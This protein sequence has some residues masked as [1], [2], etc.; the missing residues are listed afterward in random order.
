MT[1]LLT[2]NIQ[3][4]FEIQFQIFENSPITKKQNDIRIKLTNLENRE[5]GI[6]TIIK[7]FVSLFPEKYKFLDRYEPSLSSIDEKRQLRMDFTSL[8][9]KIYMNHIIYYLIKNKQ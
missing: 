6:K 5:N 8:Q 4:P 9:I 3:L 7:N 2:E 1:D